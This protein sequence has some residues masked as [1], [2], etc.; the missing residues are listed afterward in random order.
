LECL[1][2]L[3]LLL[4]TTVGNPAVRLQQDS[5]A[6]VLLAVP[7]V[8]WA[9]CRA[10]GAED[11]FV[12]AVE[13]AALGF[14]LAVLTALQNLLAYRNVAARVPDKCDVHLVVECSSVGMA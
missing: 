9:R 3:I 6:E 11:A 12:E 10:A 8:T 5:G 7:P 1:K 4:V 13:L 2:T 14:R